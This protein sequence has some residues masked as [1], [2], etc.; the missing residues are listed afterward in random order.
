VY[1]DST[2]LTADTDYRLVK[3]GRTGIIQRTGSLA[4]AWSTGGGWYGGYGGDYDGCWPGVETVKVSYRAGYEEDE[5]PEDLA[6]AVV[7]I[8][9]GYYA[10]QTAV[11]QTASAGGAVKS[12][13]RGQSQVVFM[14][15]QES[16]TS[17]TTTTV[18]RP[19]GATPSVMAVLDKYREIISA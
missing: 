8:A 13:R 1:P 16:S 5:I 12:V 7:Q 19:T 15:P 4:R 9:A 14:T 10:E 2:K 17:G 18:V 11:Q 6:G 3:D